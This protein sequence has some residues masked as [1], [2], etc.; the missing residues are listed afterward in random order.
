V[1]AARRRNRP[2]GWEFPGGKLEPGETPAAAIER[3]LHE[4]LGITVRALRPI[5]SAQDERVE[6]QLWHVELLA[7]EPAARHDHDALARLSAAELADVG[8]LPVDRELL[9]AVRDLL[10]HPRRTDRPAGPPADPPADPDA[11]LPADPD[12][13]L[14]RRS[15]RRP[16]RR[17]R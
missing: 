4:E 14:G 9:A 7:G 11:D 6:L 2:R 16:G 17:P 8:W 15:G 13:D 12:A 5:A 10:A 1:L 3:E